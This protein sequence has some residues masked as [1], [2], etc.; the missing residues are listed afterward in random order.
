MDLGPGHYDLARLFK[1]KGAITH[2][3]DR[4]PAVVKLGKYFNYEVYEMDLKKLKFSL[5][6][7]KYDGI[8]C[9][10]SINAFWFKD[11]SSLKDHITQICELVK[12][13]AWGWIVPWNGIPKTITKKEEI[14]LI[15]K[16]QKDTFAKYGFKCYELER[17]N[18][19]KY[20]VTGVV[21]NTPLFIKN[22]NI[23]NNIKK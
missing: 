1:N 9:K 7:I 20:G 8:F 17:K 18:C 6:P 19:I 22:L 12:D 4:D 10:F 21:S 15:L 2:N 14:K 13:D 11:I 23:P 5:F 3:I 16:T